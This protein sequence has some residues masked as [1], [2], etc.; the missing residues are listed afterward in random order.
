MEIKKIDINVDVN[1]RNAKL[2][3]LAMNN[4]RGSPEKDLLK[5]VIEDNEGYNCIL[6]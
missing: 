2:L 4:L 6:R 1:D 5:K 3:T